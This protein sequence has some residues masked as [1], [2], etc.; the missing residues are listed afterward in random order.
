VRARGGK[1]S[2]EQQNA[3]RCATHDHPQ[4]SVTV[5]PAAAV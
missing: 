5:S 2:E 1:G 4:M 3:K